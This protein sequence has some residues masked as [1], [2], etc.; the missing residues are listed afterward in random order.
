[1]AEGVRPVVV[2]D[3]TALRRRAASRDA[4]EFALDAVLG[5]GARGEPTGLAAAAVE[6][7]RAL[8]DAGT[9]IVAV[10]LPTGVDDDQ[11][12]IARRAVRADLTVTFGA[13]K[14]GHVLYPGRAFAG[15]VEVVDIGLIRADPDGERHPFEVTTAMAMAELVPAR[16]PRAH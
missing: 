11:R 10:D 14:R 1:E 3:E 8:D 15:A 9:H 7:L 12:A 16:D 6:G 13:W 5:T 4:W 2:A